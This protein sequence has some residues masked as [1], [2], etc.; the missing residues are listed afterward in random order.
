MAWPLSIVSKRWGF[1]DRGPALA[2]GGPVRAV[3][4]E[5][6]PENA[7]PQ[8]TVSLVGLQR[9]VCLLFGSVISERGV[10]FSVLRMEVFHLTA[11]D[12]RSSPSI[13]SVRMASS[14]KSA[15]APPRSYRIDGREVRKFRINHFTNYRGTQ[16]EGTSGPNMTH[17]S[18]RGPEPATSPFLALSLL[19]RRTEESQPYGKTR[20]LEKPGRCQ[21]LVQ[22]GTCSQ[23]SC[24]CTKK[25]PLPVASR[26]PATLAEIGEKLRG[27][28][29]QARGVE[30][31]Q[32]CKRDL[33]ALVP[34][35][36]RYR[37]GNVETTTHEVRQPLF[38]KNLTVPSGDI[39]AGP[40]C[41]EQASSC[42]KSVLENNCAPLE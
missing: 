8:K 19:V 3:L 11:V 10:T 18:F 29:D 27:F 39:S 6:I 9:T 4:S 24:R 32:T 35:P 7:P 34:R 23:G 41:R 17:H 36:P 25:L 37:V 15:L 22:G 30:C 31:D 42:L 14:D 16:Y 28:G 1:Q 12:P 26:P 40:F 2:A 5:E 13:L 21:L 20:A 33:R 38:E